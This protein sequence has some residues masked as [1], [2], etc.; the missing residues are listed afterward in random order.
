MSAALKELR[1][2]EETH[3]KQKHIIQTNFKVVISIINKIQHSKSFNV[4]RVTLIFE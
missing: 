1:F 3:Y 4:A 2:L